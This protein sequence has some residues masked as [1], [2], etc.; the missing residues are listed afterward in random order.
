MKR[1]LSM[2][3]CIA[4]V[5]S[6]LPADALAA[7]EE[8]AALFAVP[9]AETDFT[10]FVDPF[11][12]TDVDYGQLF[13][14]SVAP[15]G[16]MKLSPDTYPHDTID[17][18]GYDYTKNVIMG[19]SHT[20][21]EGVGGSGAGGNLL[22]TPSYVSFDQ[23][24]SQAA[25]AMNIVK[26]KT[27]NKVEAA[28][29]GYYSVNLWP[30]TGVN[31]NAAEDR[32][33][34]S[35]KA[36]VTA[37]VRTGYQ[38][39][40]LPADGEVSLTLDMG[41]TYQG[42]GNR[43]Q[44]LTVEQQQDKVL[45]S[46]RFASGN[47]GGSGKFTMYFYMEVKQ[48]ALEISVWNGNEFRALVPGET[49]NGEDIGAVV[50]LLARKDT[51][52]EIK[53]SISP[54]STEQAK[55]DMY[56]EM[57]GWDFELERGQ[58][59]D[60]WNDILSK[61]K[62]TSSRTSDPDG[63]LKKLFYTHLYHMFTMPMNAT[64]TDGTYRDISP[65]NN[66]KVA[67]GYTHYDSWTLWDDFKKYPIIGMVMPDVYADFVRSIA[68]GL[69]AG[70]A[71]WS[72]DYQVIPNVRTEHAVALLADGVSKGM[73]DIPNLAPAY[74]AAKKISDGVSDSD[75][76]NRVDKMVEY[77]YDDWCI[78]LLARVLFD[79][80]GDEK[81]MTDYA[82]YSARA[83]LY[84]DLYRADAVDPSA[85]KDMVGMGE[86]AVGTAPMGLL[87]GKEGGR[88]D[89]AWRGGNPEV[90]GSGQG[91]YQGSLWQY[92]FWEGNDVAGLMDLMGGKDAMY[93]QLSF[94]MGEYAPEDGYRMLH[95]SVNEIDLHSPY[96][97]NYVGR[98]SRTQYWT[99]QIYADKSF[100]EGYASSTRVKDYL[101]KLRP[102]GYMYTMDDDAGTM[103]SM[104][105]AAAMGLFPVT[106]GDPTFQL[107]SPF[108]EEIRLDVG[109]GREFVIQS[110]NVSHENK[111]IQSATLNGTS[112][113]RT[114][115]SY[116]EISRGG[117]LH[118]E[119]DKDPSNWASDCAPAPSMSDSVDSSVYEKEAIAYSSLTFHEAEANDGSADTKL[120]IT[121]RDENITLTPVA[122]TVLTADYYAVSG[123]P[124]G[125]TAFIRVID[126]KTME[127]TL[128]GRAA[129]H[130]ISAS[131]DNLKLE[132][133]DALFSGAVTTKRR[134]QMLKVQ[135]QDDTVAYSDDVIEEVGGTFDQKITAT[136]YGGADFTGT[137]G[138][139]FISSGKLDAANL[140]EGMI[141]T[142]VK[143]DAKTLELHFTG[144]VTGGYTDR[145]GL[146]L[147]YED[148]AF[149]GATAFQV[150]GSNFGGMKAIK[151]ISDARREHVEINLAR[152][153]L[154][155]TIKRAKEID[156]TLYTEAAIAVLTEAITEAEIVLADEEATLETLQSANDNIKAAIAG[157]A[158]IWDGH[159]RIEF[160]SYSEIGGGAGTEGADGGTVVK[161]TVP[162]AWV[163][164]KNVMF[165]DT[166]PKA[167]NIRY[168]NNSGRCFANANI[169]LRLGSLDGDL[170][171]TLPTPATGSS[172]G[173]YGNATILLEA[174]AQAKLTG[175]QDIYLKFCGSGS[176]SYA[177]NFNWFEF[178]EPVEPEKPAIDAYKKVEAEAYSSW[179]DA[180]HPGNKNPMKTEAAGNGGS[181]NAV[182]N[183]FDGAWI[184]YDRVN[185]GERGA[186][187]LTINYKAKGGACPA[188]ARLEVRLGSPDGALAATVM[189]PASGTNWTPWTLA[190]A[191]LSAEETALLTGVVD[192][193]YLVF[194]GDMSA[195][196]SW[197][198]MNLDYV[199]FE[200]AAAAVPTVDPYSKLE[201]ENFTL[202][203]EGIKKE[204]NDGGTTIGGT[205][206][207]KW[208]GFEKV[209]F[210]EAGPAQVVVRYAGNS[211]RCPADA[212]I[213]LY[214]D[215][216]D[217]EPVAKLAT[218][219]NAASWGEYTTLTIPLDAEIQKALTG[220]HNIY[221]KFA[222]TAAPS[223]EFVANLNWF[224]FK[225]E[226]QHQ[227]KHYGQ[228]E[229]ENYDAAA[230]NLSVEGDAVIHN[231]YDGAWLKYEEC[232]FDGEGLGDFTLS[233]ASNASRMGANAK[234]LVY[235]DDMTGETPDL[236]VELPATAPNA[237]VFDTVRARFDA[238]VTGTHDLYVVLKADTDENH[239]YV[240]KLDWMKLG[241]Y[242]EDLYALSDLLTLMESAK[243][244][245]DVQG[246]MEN[247]FKP[248]RD[249][250]LKGNRLV[251]AAIPDDGELAVALAELTA[252]ERPIVAALVNGELAMLIRSCEALDET[253][254]AEE[255]LAAIEA[256]LPDAQAITSDS[257]YAA[258]QD[259]F[260]ALE[261]AYMTRLP[262]SAKQA[263]AEK[264]EAAQAAMDDQESYMAD[265]KEEL[266]AAIESTQAVLENSE[267]TEQEIQGALR[268]LERAIKNLVPMTNRDGME[269]AME[270]AAEM[271]K[272]EISER[273][274]E[275]LQTAIAE[276]QAL[277]D[278]A[279]SI[280]APPT[281]AEYSIAAKALEDGMTFAENDPTDEQLAELE[282]LIEELQGLDLEGYTKASV[283]AL[284]AAL[285]SAEALGETPAKGEL[286]AAIEQ[287][288]AA[289]NGLE[290]DRVE[291]LAA[292]TEAEAKLQAAGGY[293]ADSVQE[294]R[295]AL[296]AAKNVYDDAEATVAEVAAAA[297]SVRTA[298]DGL[299][300][301]LPPYTPPPSNTTTKTEKN[302]DGS[303]TKTVTDKK[304]G[305]V[306]E[307][308]TYP[309]GTKIVATT[310]KDG[311]TAIE[312]TVPKDKDS[313]T[314][315][316]PTKEQPKPGEVAVIINEDGTREVIK[317]SVST[318]DGLRVTLTGNAKLEIIDNSKSFNDVPADHWAADA[319]AFATSRELFTGGDGGFR[320]V[321]NMSR[322]MLFTVLARL[323]GQDLTESETWYSTAMDWAKETG[324]SDG[325]NPD[326]SITRESLAVMLYRYAGSPDT[327]GMA[328]GE[329]ADAGD[330]SGWAQN[331]MLWCVE[332]GILKGSSNM[333]NPNGTATR[334]EVVIMLQRFISI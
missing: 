8:D 249:T 198:I 83:F 155:L 39:Y 2:A 1:L 176:G 95:T 125:L 4:I 324:I 106:P 285:D 184:K 257:G 51:P 72:H 223:L 100:T 10:Q 119:M 312:V 165:G 148:S 311:K 69:E 295:D 187:R 78:S 207:G 30:K 212:N 96:L 228:V 193:V 109:N 293:T 278:R 74:E 237:Y 294:L 315:T 210:G 115:L 110:N 135:F 163:S 53:T 254:T 299:V 197:Y 152:N 233:Y 329:F 234:A 158:R 266:A 168:V 80:T 161:N 287:L 49:V 149:E 288:K 171:A 90:S 76:R 167:V 54:I 3:L 236:I 170:V 225:P 222:G 85:Y 248:L 291:L 62:V 185:F 308:T 209:N 81:Y 150:V 36:E 229:A 220:S 24:P 14:G 258:Y 86:Q 246:N 180:K 306:T 128:T 108:F 126:G 307:T 323:D 46:G 318:E 84:K 226:K 121:V 92:S 195:N 264:L 175:M 301:Y 87:W 25:R 132:L 147:T 94:L 251:N 114:W 296:S 235:L 9:T 141:L 332:S 63:H 219:P 134:T 11:V 275:M 65:Q 60:A 50:T 31:D 19:F 317:T 326:A 304:T 262:V 153:E 178:G 172:W 208:I 123:V 243:N 328:L 32:S 269:E 283:E 286:V 122:E 292:I 255:S 271:L 263:L 240:A 221:L 91:L 320:P 29:P 281:N 159:E 218:P 252:L 144:A 151:I 231:T 325:T 75:R 276:A 146:M 268:A 111:Y 289:R 284:S 169:E 68:D 20:R 22:V 26:D 41:F 77:C 238:P 214:L 162:G 67:D 327:E 192:D 64:S 310:P 154:A 186:C 277:L 156:E 117:V 279:G 265:S 239:P 196:P 190:V 334:A 70:F 204:S 242:N 43:D 34:G 206:F 164:Y 272:G 145:D 57:P 215:S 97:F 129:A 88:P 52:L 73:N 261:Q 274:H 282:A 71:T 105:V 179:T 58:V 182:A 137:V 102:D 124:E 319:I 166:G 6:M 305:E 116:D 244:K 224:Y 227:T 133:K 13:P 5:L 216:M 160:E 138:E 202:G 56:V 79:Q 66:V 15:S 12:G 303:T 44:T 130:G 313:V 183:T 120:T 174:A 314:L 35:I 42:C 200:E 173:D 211:G 217:G 331:A 157:L 259:A 113:D 273:A 300:V 38:R 241:E 230:E 136:I 55:R 118:Y 189:A 99:R 82:K 142:A 40:T 112:F 17:H 27:G 333:L 18:C 131:I 232:V 37:D 47:V 89:G 98:P 21:I 203:G 213:E 199:Q 16:L 28:K 101:Y 7:E 205:N 298:I 23:K 309:D 177:G 45:L 127:M 270:R 188:D 280:V 316:L 302:P 191:E 104:Y 297:G 107:T 143:K 253:N 194:K 330:I 33:L 93:R 260:T 250:L 201:F 267:A 103:A 48:P 139:D 59:K 290:V 140:P 181:G 61:V 245:R 321:G 322:A 256:L 247:L